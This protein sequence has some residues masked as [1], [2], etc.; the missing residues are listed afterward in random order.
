[1]SWKRVYWRYPSKRR[2]PL[3]NTQKKKFIFYKLKRIF[4]GVTNGKI[5]KENQK[6]STTAVSRPLETPS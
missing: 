6:V 3:K 5:V 1:M 4:G 2:L